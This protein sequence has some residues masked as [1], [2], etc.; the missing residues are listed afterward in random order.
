MPHE[1][2]NLMRPHPRYGAFEGWF[3]SAKSVAAPVVGE[4]FRTAGPE[5]TSPSA[6][7]SGTGGLYAEGRWSPKGM[8]KVVY[9]GAAPETSFL[10]ATE[11][12][13]YFQLPLSEGMPKVTVTVEVAV[14]RVV[15]IREGRGFAVPMSELLAED[16]RAVLQGKNEPT[17]HDIGRAAFT[18][19]IQGLLVNSKP[20]AGGT[21]LVLFPANFDKSCALKVRNPERL[22]QMGR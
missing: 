16:W 7:V 4:Y 6:I 1:V 12:R 9:L 3:Q 2:Q 17:T 13:R 21:N 8:S 18:A 5:Y 11:T 15:D 22:K 20:H 19:G 14:S 10:E